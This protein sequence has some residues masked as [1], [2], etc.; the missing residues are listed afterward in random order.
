MIKLEENKLIA[1]KDPKLK[2][3]IKRMRIKI[4]IRINQRTTTN[5]ILNGEIKKTNQFNKKIPKQT[6]KKNEYQIEKKQHITNQ[7]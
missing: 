2:I 7:D 3:T 1:Q 6:N 4:E 5:F